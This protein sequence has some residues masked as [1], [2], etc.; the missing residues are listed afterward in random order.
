L[1]QIQFKFFALPLDELLG[2]VLRRRDEVPQF[3]LEQLGRLVFEG[4]VNSSNF[5]DIEGLVNLIELRPMEVENVAGDCFLFVRM[6]AR[7]RRS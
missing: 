5:V 7:E 2:V 1:V 4:V 3:D 6:S